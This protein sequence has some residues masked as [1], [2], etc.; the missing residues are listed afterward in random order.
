MLFLVKLHEDIVHAVHQLLPLV[1]DRENETAAVLQLRLEGLRDARR[2]GRDHDR[3]E[4]RGL[5]P[6]QVAVPR[7]HLDVGVAE[8]LQ[9]GRRLLGERRHDLDRVDAR[10]DL[11]QD[12]GLIAGAGAD[13]EHGLA[14]LEAQRLR[15]EADDVR[16]RD[17]L[18]VADGHR[19]ILVGLRPERRGNE[20]VPLYLAHRRERARVAH[21]PR[22]DLARHH[23]L[24]RPREGR[25]FGVAGGAAGE[26]G[27]GHQPGH[28]E[29]GH[30][31]PIVA[32]RGRSKA[33]LTS[34]A[35]VESRAADP[36][37]HARGRNFAVPSLVAAEERVREMTFR[38]VYEATPRPTAAPLS[39]YYRPSPACLANS[40]RA[41]RSSGDSWRL[42][43]SARTSTLPASTMER[44]ISGFRSATTP[45]AE[46]PS[47]AGG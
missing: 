6:A 22:G 46:Q 4:G 47:H 33:D 35:A 11:G 13:L 15:H 26:S 31:G 28:E 14:A 3:I 25:R 8:A 7:A 18:P 29:Q 32:P 37:E 38:N 43:P 44:R 5:G 42:T 10:G 40:P 17:R 27:Q 12:R 23:L 45:L 20:Q 39:A 1:P 19:V 21:A 36:L 2:G 30:A 34:E 41:A 9:E 16:L 24:A